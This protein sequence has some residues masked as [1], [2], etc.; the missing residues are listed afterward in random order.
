MRASMSI[1]GVFQPVHWNNMVLVDGGL[2]NNYPVDIAKKMGADI[3]IGVDVQEGLAPADKLNTLTEVLGQIINLMVENKYD[4][5]I[6]KSDLHIKVNAKDYSAA[7]FTSTAIDSL[8]HRGEEAG[9]SQWDSLK[10]LKKKI[11]I[12]DEYVAK[13]HGPFVIPL[14]EKYDIVPEIDPGKNQQTALT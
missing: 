14:K 7:S 5:N 3:I 2:S 1:P 11:G 12:S 13:R 8:L 10:L 9:R 6:A 4:E